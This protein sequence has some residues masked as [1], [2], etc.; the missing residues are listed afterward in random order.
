MMNLMDHEKH[1]NTLTR[2]YQQK[3]NQKVYKIAL[4]GNFTCPNIDG[5][6][7]TKGCSFCSSMGSG[8]FAGEKEMSLKDQFDTQKKMMQA[9]WKQ[10]AYIIYFQANNNTHA[11]VSRL[12]ALFEEAITLDPNIVLLSIATRPDALPLDVLDYLSEL[13]QKIP[14]QIELGLQTIFQKTADLVNRAHDLDCFVQAVS[15]LRKRKIEVVCHLINGLPFETK[16]M[17]IETAKFLNT[18]D[19]Q[20]VKIHMLHLM[21]HTL[22]GYQYQNQP[23]ELLSLEAYVDIVCEQLGWLKKEIIIHRLTGDAPRSTLI[24]PKW[25]LKKFVVTNEIDKKMR[26]MNLFQGDYDEKQSHR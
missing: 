24:A 1:Y 21:E 12:K 15:N 25:T 16:D 10:G 22:M 14:V 4:N 23:W 3:Y 7:A 19:I 17:M 9:K 5:T 26:K 11:P 8:D 2:Y 13:N 20:G 18:L 6:V